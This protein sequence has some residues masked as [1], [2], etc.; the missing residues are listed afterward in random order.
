MVKKSRVEGDKLN[1]QTLIYNGQGALT[2]DTSQDRLLWEAFPPIRE[3]WNFYKK[4]FGDDLASVSFDGSIEERRRYQQPVTVAKQ[5]ALT[6]LVQGGLKLDE[7]NSIDLGFRNEVDSSVGL[8]LGEFNS[9]LA[10]GMT[11]LKTLYRA[12][13]FRNEIMWGVNKG[14]LSTYLGVTPENLVAACQ[15]E[16]VKDLALDKLDGNYSV[17]AVAEVRQRIFER[18]KKE[19]KVKKMISTDTRGAIHTE[20]FNEA[21][22]YFAQYLR[23]LQDEIFPPR[24]DVYSGA[25]QELYTG[26]VEDTI[27][28]GEDHMC[29]RFYFGSNLE[30]AIKKQSALAKGVKGFTHTL[31]VVGQGAAVLE[32]S[33]V[34]R[35]AQG[36]KKSAQAAGKGAEA[37]GD[38]E[39]KVIETV[40]SVIKYWKEKGFK[41]NFE[42]NLAP[43]FV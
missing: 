19:N 41:P 6:A 5:A 25:A 24:F 12:I 9:W 4:L 11:N 7:H 10:A 15:Q 16:G 13:R 33:I 28:K 21:A 18:L 31:L 34:R 38:L 40:P 27:Q 26:F 35:V 14:G 2:E 23:I 42:P 17:G 32:K 43:G 36:V 39:T 8:S 20:E 22:G 30:T 3:V 37:L 1:A 29:K